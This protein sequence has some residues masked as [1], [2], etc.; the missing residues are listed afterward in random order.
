MH[1]TN[2]AIV[3]TYFSAFLER[4]FQSPSL[5]VG[6]TMK[7]VRNAD[8]NQCVR[9][10]ESLPPLHGPPRDGDTIAYKVESCAV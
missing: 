4:F 3:T 2:R 6:E 1:S 9:N 7:D 8:K 5:A 10:Y